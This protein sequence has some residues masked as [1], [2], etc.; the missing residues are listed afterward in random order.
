MK[1][2]VADKF[3]K[4]G[5]DG[6][7]ALGCEVLNDPNAGATGLAGLVA[8]HDPEVLIVRSTKV[9]APVF[10]GAKKLKLIVRAGSGVDNIDVPAASKHGV[11]V[12]NC[13]GMNAVA[14]AELTM[15]LILCCDRRVADQCSSAKAG[16]WNKK[17]FA[18]AK[19]LKGLTLGVAGTGAIGKEVIKR[20][21]AF[22]MNV[23]AWSD[24]LTPAEAQEIG[25]EFGGTQPAHL[26]DFAKRCD[27]VSVHIPLVEGTK[28]LFGKQFFDAMKP[29]S[30]FINTS[31]GGV[32]DEAALREAVKSKNLR[33]GLDVYDPQP[34]DTESA[35]QCETANLPGVYTTHHCGA[36]TDQAQMAVADEAVRIVK[37][38]KAE[39][40]AENCVNAEAVKAR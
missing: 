30:Y 27:V 6:L 19:G 10:E 24:H 34:T 38:F 29:G 40:R 28:K 13:P 17:E 32:V 4:A 18:K 7:K 37:V 39:G 16:K 33:V 11:S 14:V 22:G 20:A 31:R 21:K 8:T 1:V 26:I 2:F 35:W 25:C 5:L 3:E 23:V 9:Q 12:C 15:A 36:S